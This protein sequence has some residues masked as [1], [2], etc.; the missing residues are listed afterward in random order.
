M[1]E[2]RHDDPLII[3]DSGDQVICPVPCATCDELGPGGCEDC[4][5]CLLWPELPPPR[6]RSY[7][8]LPGRTSP[9]RTQALQARR[10]ALDIG[11]RIGLVSRRHRRLERLS[12]RALADALGWS[13]PSLNRAERH[14]ASLSVH[15][16]E[17]LLRHAG[18]R[19]AIVPV[20]TDTGPGHGE[21]PDETWG[22]VE[23]LARDARGRRLPPHGEVTWNSESDRGLV[24][25]DVEPEPEWTWRR[26]R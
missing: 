15:K 22:T 25:G 1:D 24:H 14:G 16:I 23:L 4:L 21:D 18:F 26:P 8:D 3:D 20:G 13:Q 6:D 12:Q 2:E 9:L 10:T 7:P 5:D 11:A 17:S 19:L